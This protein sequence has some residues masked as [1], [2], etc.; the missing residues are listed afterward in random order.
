[1]SAEGGATLEQVVTALCEHESFV[2]VSHVK[3]D[4][5]T[6]GAGLAL[7]LGLK[8]L[9]KRV[10]Y[11]QQDPVPRN[12]RFLPDA[13][14][15]RR[16]FGTLP[17]RTMFCFFDMS[18]VARAGPF[19]PPF[20]PARSL[21]V[22]HH[23]GN[24]RF[25]AL[26]YILE[27]EASTGTVVL[28]ILQALGTAMTP[29]IAEC[30]LTTVMTDTGAFMHS[31]TTPDVLRT[32]ARLMEAGAD[33]ERITREI[34]ANKRFSAQRLMGEAL[35]RMRFDQEAGV[36]WTA[37]DAQMLAQCE[38]DA[39]DTEDIVQQLRVI[40][41]CKVAVL[42][43]A[44]EPGEVRVSL[45]SNGEVNVQCVAAHLGGGGHFRAAGCTFEGALDGAVTAIAEA[46][47]AEGVAA[48]MPAVP[49]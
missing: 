26:N 14:A 34:F 20:D 23:L 48:K 46:L 21:N 5:D 17:E 15:V 36:V 45:R 9:G 7:G 42:F 2:M 29:Q 41:G 27:T 12:L 47:R 8:Q 32:S 22:D 25:A 28:R 33:K 10:A 11:F 18:D 1:M 19:L 40:D 37:V 39:E 44:V 43:K 4:G 30:I 35:A 13:G 3:P 6:L 16:E 49:V 38:A 31:N 24:T